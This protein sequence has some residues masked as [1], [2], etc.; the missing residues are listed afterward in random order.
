M[1]AGAA[2]AVAAASAAAGLCCREH[3]AVSLPLTSS[4]LPSAIVSSKL[5]LG[6]SSATQDPIQSH[7]AVFSLSLLLQQ[8]QY[9]QQSSKGCTA[10]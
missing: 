6:P 1:T 7:T 2:A 3:S 9:E 4:S 10:A 8:Q 5:H